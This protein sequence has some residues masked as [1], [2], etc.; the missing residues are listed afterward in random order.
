MRNI[1]C[2]VFSSPRQEGTRGVKICPEVHVF[3]QKWGQTGRFFLVPIASL[4]LK[5]REF[6][7]KDA[8]GAKGIFMPL[9]NAALRKRLHRFHADLQGGDFTTTDDCRYRIA[10]PDQ[11]ELLHL[12]PMRRNIAKKQFTVLLSVRRLPI[13]VER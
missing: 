11:A 5:M 7:R 4:R 1:E 6:N 13:H 3:Y 8:K 9:R 10:L 2:T 12:L